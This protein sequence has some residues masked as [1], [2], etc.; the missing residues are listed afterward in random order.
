MV[1]RFEKESQRLAALP[2]SERFEQLIDFPSDFSMK[3]IGKSSDSFWSQ[4]R[5]ALAGCGHPDVILVE[6]RS[7][8]GKFCS[9]SFTVSVANGVAL[10]QVYAAIESIPDLVCLL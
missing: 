7:A 8:K 9:L 4:V 1:T 2:R 5:Q 6:R 3:A 10:D